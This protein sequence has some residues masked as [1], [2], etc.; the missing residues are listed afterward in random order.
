MSDWW[1]VADAAQFVEVSRRTISRWVHDGRITH[2]DRNG[3]TLV[4]LDELAQLVDHR[5]DGGRLPRTPRA[6]R[7]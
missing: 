4:D 1:P 5:G 7:T 2:R 3:V 6:S